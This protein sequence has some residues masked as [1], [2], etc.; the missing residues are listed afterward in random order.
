MDA[1]FERR[2]I[3]NYIDKPIPK[4]DIEK[5]LR[6]GMSAPSAGNE[7]PWQFIVLDDKNIMEGIT[8]LHPYSQMLK[9]ASHAI[10][11]CGDMNFNRYNVD[12]WVED[13]SAAAENMLIM[14]QSLGIGSVWLGVYPTADRVQGIKGY[15]KLPENVI[16]FSIVSLGYPAE[17]KNTQD[18]Y[19]AVRVH[20]NK[21]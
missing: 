9:Q 15:L 13:C 10:V 8:K 3:R 1:I 6:A 17:K 5:I 20:W 19:D 11:I 14:A 12:Y 21:W 2:S 4:E 7:R 18:R 16:P